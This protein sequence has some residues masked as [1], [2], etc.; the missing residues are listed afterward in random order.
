MIGGVGLTDGMLEFFLVV[1]RGQDDRISVI[2]RRM[3]QQLMSALQGGDNIPERTEKLVILMYYIIHSSASLEDVNDPLFHSII[4]ENSPWLLSV[5]QNVLASPS[6]ST[7]TSPSLHKLILQ[8]LT[9]LFSQSPKFAHSKLTP[10]INLS[11][12]YF[13]SLIPH[14][15]K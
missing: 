2:N 5:Y 13:N 9:L 1:Y 8:Q 10:L 6:T 11:W 12:N 3:M 14:Y 7:T 4:T 15:L